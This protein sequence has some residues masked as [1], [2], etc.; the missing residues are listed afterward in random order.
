MYI[1]PF[2][3][4]ARRS[5]AGLPRTG[6]RRALDKKGDKFD[7]LLKTTAPL[8]HSLGEQVFDLSI[9]GSE[10]VLRPCGEAFP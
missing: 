4:V 9:D 1:P 10:V 3:S 7:L 6:L 2:L 8:L 5:S